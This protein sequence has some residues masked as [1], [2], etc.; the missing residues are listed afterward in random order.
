VEVASLIVIQ[1]VLKHDLG[2]SVSIMPKL[3]IPILLFLV[4]IF[5]AWRVALRA[6]GNASARPFVVLIGAA[7]MQS[8]LVSLRW[9]FG[10]TNFRVAQIALSCSLPALAWVSFSALGA[11]ATLNYS[12][13]Q[14]LHVLP[15]IFAIIAM[16][17]APELVDI[18]IIITFLGY[19]FA[20]LHLL[21]AGSDGLTNIVFDGAFNVQ[22]ALLLVVFMLFG[23]ALIDFLVFIDFATAAGAHAVWFIA[24]GNFAWLIVIGISAVLTTDALPDEEDLGEAA[25]PTDQR[26]DDED[27]QTEKLVGETL[28]S[29]QLYKDE[30]LTLTRLAR[31][32]GVPAR[33]VSRAINRSHNCNVSQYVNAMR[34]TEACRLLKETDMPITSVIYE[35]GFQTKSNFNREFLRITGKIPRDW[36][37]K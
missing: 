27:I 10:I 2:H 1:D 11:R 29:G 13:R 20:F 36:R 12:L 18:I 16:W 31:R 32:C 21:R 9:D 23:S 26:P 6:R 19:G 14:G 35:S 3:S 34:I 37:D 28:R 8:L 25:P 24:V 22:R 17:L 15:A 33:Q 30:N 7:A 5:I 4:L